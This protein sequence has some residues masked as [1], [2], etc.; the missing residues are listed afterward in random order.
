MAVTGGLLLESSQQR[1][2]IVD[3]NKDQLIAATDDGFNAVKF[4]IGTVF[5]VFLPHEIVYS[6][7]SA[8]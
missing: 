6:K 2:M 8:V 3:T 1:V 5:G 7:V 4:D